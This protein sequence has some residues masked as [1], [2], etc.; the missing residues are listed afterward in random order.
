MQIKSVEYG[1]LQSN[2][3]RRGHVKVGLRGEVEEGDDFLQCYD[4]IKRVVKNLVEEE[5]R[6]QKKH[7]KKPVRKAG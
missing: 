6:D 1:E 4:Q 7:Q 5:L 3:D 2:N